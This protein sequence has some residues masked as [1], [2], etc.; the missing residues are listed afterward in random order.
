MKTIEEVLESQR[1]NR[2]EEE[3]EKQPEEKCKIELRTI[4]PTAIEG[5]TNCLALT[6]KKEYKLVVIKN[7]VKK[8]L[9]VSWKIALSTFVMNFLKAFL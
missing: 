7:M 1:E 2:I 5:N 6:V 9:K 8:G 3:R 4:D